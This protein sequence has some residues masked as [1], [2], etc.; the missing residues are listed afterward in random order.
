MT[1]EEL[2]VALAKAKGTGRELDAELFQRFGGRAWNAAF[3]FAQEPCGC[4]HERAVST[5]RY[6]APAYTAS[7]DAAVTLVP[8]GFAW[9]LWSPDNKLAAAELKSPQGHVFYGLTARDGLP[10]LALCIAR[11]EYEL[12]K[13]DAAE[14]A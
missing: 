10:A 5:A 7:I 11:V 12:Q 13:Q 9:H 8:E 6:R 4:P 1:L 14:A 2:R 3:Q